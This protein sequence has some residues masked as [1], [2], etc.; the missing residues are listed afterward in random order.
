MRRSAAVLIA[1]LLLAAIPA[2][3]LAADEVFTADLSGDAQ[4]PPIAVDGTGEATVT[5]SDDEST[6][7]WEITY[8]GLTGDPAAGHIHVGPTDGTGPVMI[9]FA[10]VSATGSS[11][12]FAA[13]DYTT[14]D[15]LPADWAGVLDAI[16]DGN[17]YVNIHTAANQ[18]GEIRGQ[19]QGS[20]APPPTD[21]VATAEAPAP[22]V[23]TGLLMA[24]TLVALTAFVV[25]MRRTARR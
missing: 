8:S 1:G 24:L 17:A 13:A 4:V 3:A 23:A 25:S 19:L 5:I 22:V 9:P 2:T 12:S 21:T 10:S 6:V 14:G 15:G 16:R 20:V 11:G 7:S 18:A